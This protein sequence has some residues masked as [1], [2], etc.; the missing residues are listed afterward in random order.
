MFQFI[1]HKAP[2]VFADANWQDKREVYK[3]TATNR[4]KIHHVNTKCHWSVIEN[5]DNNLHLKCLPR[6][7]G[8]IRSPSQPRKLSAMLGSMATTL[9]L[10]IVFVR[11]WRMRL[12]LTLC[13]FLQ[14][15]HVFK[16]YHSE[17]LWI[18]T[19]NKSYTSK[20]L[21]LVTSQGWAANCRNRNLS[22]FRWNW[23]AP[24]SCKLLQRT[25]GLAW[26]TIIIS[27]ETGFQSS[28]LRLSIVCCL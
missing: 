1:S 9:I 5:T 12:Y 20:G 16:L 23:R 13:N 8:L 4:L 27:K 19:C 18:D 17:R 14:W 26:E 11:P 3:P 22:G 10:G 24:A 21:S 28:T 15:I 2:N 7:T 6:L 25:T